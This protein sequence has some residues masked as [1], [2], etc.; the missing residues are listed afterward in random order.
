MAGFEPSRP[1][2]V[3]FSPSNLSYSHFAIGWKMLFLMPTEGNTTSR[4]KV[5]TTCVL[6][7]G[8]VS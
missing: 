2:I 1:Q 7:P 4:D 3:D 8:G 6:C 5:G